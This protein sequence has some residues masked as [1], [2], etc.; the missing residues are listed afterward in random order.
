MLHHAKPETF[1]PLLVLLVE[2]NVYVK[3]ASCI[4]IK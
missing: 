1:N 4:N 2:N 3:T